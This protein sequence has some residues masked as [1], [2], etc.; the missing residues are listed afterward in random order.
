M[1]G[2]GRT[3]GAAPRISVVLPCFNCEATLPAALDSLL[4][5]T[6]GDFEI[7][8][9]DDGSQDATAAIL[10]D[11]AR[12][13]ARVRPLSLPHGGIVA[14]LNAGLE[15]AR[16]RYVARMD[17]DDLCLPERFAV[18]ARLLD[19][20][21]SL[22]LAG[23]RVRFGGDRRAS[24]GY[25]HYV[26]WINGLLDHDTIFRNRFVE[27]PFAH[28]SLF[29]R[30]ELVDLYGPYREGPFPEDYEFILRLLEAGV[31]MAKADAELLIWNDPPQ[32][33]SRTHPSYEVDAFYALKT[34]FLAR[35]LAAHNPHHPDVI[36]LGAGR[37]TRRRAD[38][39]LQHGINIIAYADIDPRK[40]GRMVHGR[41]VLHRNDLPPA[42]ECF[43][44]SYV[45]SRGA[46]EDIRVFLQEKRWEE[47]KD[48]LMVG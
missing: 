14:A 40:V 21:P 42:G 43:C 31:R 15:Q 28:P 9:C 30:R 35:W 32:R 26:D 38:L 5:Q 10:S 12:R 3:S 29:F 33:L 19:A 4:A 6:L 48:Y 8:A 2:A 47:G 16:G 17:A 13:D 11:Y 37:T 41:P 22:G 7:L 36:V 18:Q 20:D 39:L 1:G 46:R 27:S 23:C 24:G 25:A 34:G 45:A 44:L